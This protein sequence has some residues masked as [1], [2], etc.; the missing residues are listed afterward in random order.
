MKSH[1]LSARGLN[2]NYNAFLMPINSTHGY[3]C[4]TKSESIFWISLVIDVGVRS[5]STHLVIVN[6]RVFLSLY[7]ERIYEMD[8]SDHNS[9]RQDVIDLF[10]SGMSEEYG[11]LVNKMRSKRSL[12]KQWYQ[13]T[14]PFNM[15]NPLTN[16]QD[17]PW[18]LLTSWKWTN[19]SDPPHRWH[20][21]N[22]WLRHALPWKVLFSQGSYRLTRVLTIGSDGTTVA[23]FSR[24][25]CSGA[26]KIFQPLSSLVEDE[27][28]ILGVGGQGKRSLGLHF[29]NMDNN[30]SIRTLLSRKRRTKIR[31]FSRIFI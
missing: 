20:V 6:Q 14:M 30:F 27:F 9:Y 21:V 7:F 12:R 23:Y 5:S 8:I 19:C 16:R 18:L 17:R 1:I 13:Q 3:F 11:G 31:L 2:D 25:K 22:P 15:Q 4:L 28:L 10:P 29:F 24:P 26:S